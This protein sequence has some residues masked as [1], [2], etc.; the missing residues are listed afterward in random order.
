MTLP[1]VMK[2]FSLIR[3]G[4]VLVTGLT[5]SG[6]STTLAAIIDLINATSS[7][8][9]LTIEEPIEFVHPAKK[10]I[11]C[12]REVGTDVN[13]FSDGLRAAGRQ[14]CDEVLV[15]GRRDYETISLAVR[16]AKMGSFGF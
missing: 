8:H 9:I 14:G 7:R 1:P 2:S 3:S 15:G 13:S 11:I 5:G 6:K 4:L 12:Q 10:S 16:A